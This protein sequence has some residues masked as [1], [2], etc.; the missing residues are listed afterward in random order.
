VI[1]SGG[2]PCT[3]KKGLPISGLNA[4]GQVDVEDVVVFH[5]GTKRGPK[6]EVLT[7]GGRVL[8]VTATGPNLA[9]AVER[10]YQGVKKIRFEGAQYRRD[11]AHRALKRE[12]RG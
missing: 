5:A 11:I 2:Y 8:G 10:A 7:A 9:Q 3:Y 4:A 1:A 6:G 12:M